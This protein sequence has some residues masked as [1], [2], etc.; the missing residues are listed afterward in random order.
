MTFVEAS[1]LRTKLKAAR[2]NAD[3]CVENCTRKVSENVGEISPG[4]VLQM[5]ESVNALA[6]VLEKLL[7]ESEARR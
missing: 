2:E 7:A 4:W 3:K 1:A 6:D 5:R